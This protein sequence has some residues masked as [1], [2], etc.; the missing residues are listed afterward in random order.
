MTNKRWRGICTIAV[1]LALSATTCGNSKKATSPTTTGGSSRASV[2]RGSGKKVH[3]IAPGVTDSEIRVGGV[4]SVTNPVGGK[5]GDAFAGTKAY[6]DMINSGGGIYGRQLK[7]VAERDDKLASNT[8]EIQA[9]LTEDH[10][11]AVL[12]VASLLF[13][14]ADSLAHQSIPT[15]GWLINPEWGGPKVGPKPTLFGQTGSYLC[16]ACVNY[17]YP[18]AASQVHA[19]NIG[20][21]AY[22]AAQSAGC[23]DGVEN[24]FKKYGGAVGAKVA[25]ADKSLSFGIAD[26]SVQVSKMKDKHVDMVLTCMDTNGVVTLA[27]EMKK[28][29]LHAVQYLPNGYDQGFLDEYGDLFEGAFVR[30]DFA[31]FELPEDQQPTGLKN[32]LEWTKKAG[33]KP[34]ENGVVGWLNAD[35][36]VKGL[37][38]AGPNFDRQ[39]M[40]DAI[41][42]MNDYTADG[43]VYTVD[44][45]KA[46]TA[47]RA[48]NDQC[49]FISRVKDSQFDPV[50]SK[51]GKPFV[52][53]NVEQ[54]GVTTRYAR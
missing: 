45:T 51:P 20:L 27:K 35:L 30:T 53:P 9:L 11:F 24:T 12:P 14:G 5:Y 7:L 50:Y 31:Q 10:V 15:F 37:Q 17:T 18:W 6:F 28:Q 38:K 1:L 33:A 40:V 52:C 21:L 8:S 48:L 46:H 2:S 49:Q 44:W 19:H 43:F 41:N 22:T 36:F 13:T 39:K 4:A 34:S 54:H 3:I 42:S 47:L 25:F 32:Y 23:A 16:F 29:G 26:L